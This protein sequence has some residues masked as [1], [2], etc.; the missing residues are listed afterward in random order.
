MFTI[1][2]LLYFIWYFSKNCFVCF[3][4]CL[5]AYIYIYIYY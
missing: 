3:I 2:C 5:L 1:C 4:C